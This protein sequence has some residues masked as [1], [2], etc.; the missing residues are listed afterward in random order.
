MKSLKFYDVKKRKSFM[1]SKYKFISKRNPRTKR[2][3]Y[4]A[5]ATSPSKNKAYRIVSKDFYKKNK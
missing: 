4:M 1:S 5:V 2:M 3:T